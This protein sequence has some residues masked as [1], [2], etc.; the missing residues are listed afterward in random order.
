MKIPDKETTSIER[1]Y[2]MLQQSQYAKPVEPEEF[3]FS[4]ANQKRLAFDLARDLVVQGDDVDTAINTS[5]KFIDTFYA[6]AIKQHAW[7]RK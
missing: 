3:W 1:L 5:K 2:E 4:Y 6:K 7:E